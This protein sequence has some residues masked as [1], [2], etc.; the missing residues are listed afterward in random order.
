MTLAPL[1]LALTLPAS[2]WG[3]SFTDTVPTSVFSGTDTVMLKLVIGE[4]PRLRI[5]ASPE[6]MF[7][8]WETLWL[9][10]V[11]GRPLRPY[12]REFREEP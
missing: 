9:L 5:I 12:Y 6:R 7:E 10:G 1:V 8:I 11:L 4:P 2:F 3:V